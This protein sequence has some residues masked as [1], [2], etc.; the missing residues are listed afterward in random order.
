M[1]HEEGFEHIEQTIVQVV[2]M[3]REQADVQRAQARIQRDHAQA[4]L[5]SCRGTGCFDRRGG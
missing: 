4:I 3:Q 1:T 5:A 2:D